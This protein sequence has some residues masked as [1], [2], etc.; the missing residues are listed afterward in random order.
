MKSSLNLHRVSLLLL[1]VLIHD[2][3]KATFSAQ[4]F[5]KAKFNENMENT[6]NGQVL[7]STF[8]CNA[9]AERNMPAKSLQFLKLFS[10]TNG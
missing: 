2:T 9:A 1:H 3:R 6:R 8:V 5:Q 10:K 7:P 4:I